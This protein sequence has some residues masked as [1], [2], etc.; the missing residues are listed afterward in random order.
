MT[1]LFLKVCVRSWS[2]KSF[3]PYLFRKGVRDF[4]ETVVYVVFWYVLRRPSGITHLSHRIERNESVDGVVNVSGVKKQFI[5]SMIGGSVVATSSRRYF[6]A[7]GKLLAWSRFR[8]TRLGSLYK[9]FTVSGV[10]FPGWEHNSQH[11]WGSRHSY[12][13]ISWLV[14]RLKSTLRSSSSRAPSVTS[15]FEVAFP[16]LTRPLKPMYQRTD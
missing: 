4:L 5:C 10:T 1:K 12:S 3:M 6:D 9:G 16:V 11:S 8:R 2:I 14:W 7:S 13:E 15:G